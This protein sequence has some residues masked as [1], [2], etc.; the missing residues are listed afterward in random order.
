MPQRKSS[1]TF[2]YPTIWGVSR[3]TIGPARLAGGTRQA[4]VRRGQKRCKG[5]AL[6]G[7]PRPT[8]RGRI[9]IS[10]RECVQLHRG[11]LIPSFGRQ[12]RYAWHG[13]VP[14]SEKV[15]RRPKP[16]S[17]GGST[18]GPPFALGGSI[19]MGQAK[20]KR[21]Q[22]M[23]SPC[24]CR[25]GRPAA[26]CCFD[27]VR[28][29]K[30]AARLNIRTLPT[31]TP[32]D[33][34]YM[35]DLESCQGSISGE[36]LISKSV[37][38]VL[39]GDG[40]FTISGVPWLEV[41]KEKRIA[42]NNLTANCLCKRHNSALSPLDAAAA[43]FFSALRECMEAATAPN[44][45]LFSGHDIE[46]WLLK[47]LKAMAASGNLARG[48]EKLPG[49]FQRDIDIIERLDDHLGWPDGSGLYF[50]MPSGSRMVNNTR[51][52]ISALDGWAATGN[53]GVVDQRPRP[54]IRHDDCRAGRRR[55]GPVPLAI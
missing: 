19:A 49:I 23:G 47:T 36:H 6:A 33:R 1:K 28:W 21:Q 12:A 26:Q 25:S 11:G 17:E 10:A 4:D 48:R 13:C 27:G 54:G 55:A 53:C 9:F 3:Q 50:I 46:R 35:R 14:K 20:I 32:V 5:R 18:R 42:P 31:G 8:P 34:C 41:G 24:R 40:D 16:D 15:V 51:F 37:I 29:R 2:E 38:E 43:L 45:Y 52:R 39:R 30:P 44:P 22:L 7:R